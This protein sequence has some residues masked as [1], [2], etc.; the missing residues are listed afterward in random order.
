VSS[1]RASNEAPEPRVVDPERLRRKLGVMSGKLR[2]NV[3]SG[4]KPL[5]GY[6]NV[7]FRDAPHVDVVADASRLPF[8]EGTV[9]EIASFHLVEHFRRHQLASVVLPYWHRLL[10]PGGILRT[11]CP[12]W[13][14][15]LRRLQRGDMTLPDFTLVTFGSQDY[16]G[17]DHFSMYTP[18]TFRTLLASLGFEDIDVVTEARQNGL[19]PEMEI[20]ARKAP[21]E[22]V[23][24]AEFR[25]EPARPGAVPAAAEAPSSTVAAE[26]TPLADA[27][28]VVGELLGGFRDALAIERSSFETWACLPPERY[29]GKDVLDLGC[30]IGASSASFME[31]GA[32]FVWGVDPE[33]TEDR[34]RALRLLPRSRFSSGVLHEID[35]GDQRFDVVYARVVSEHIYDLPR[36]VAIIHSLLRP[37]GCFVG[38]HDNYFGPMG[39]HDQGMFAAVEGSEPMRIERRGPACWTVPEKCEASRDFR[40]WYAKEHDRHALDWA[41]TPESCE[42]CPYYR[43]AQMWGHLLYQ[44]DFPRVYAGE[45]FRTLK[46]GGLNKVTPYQLRQFLVEAGF[47]VTTWKPVMVANAPPAELLERFSRSDLQTGPILFSADRASVASADPRHPNTMSSCACCPGRG[48]D[49]SSVGN[50]KS[51]FSA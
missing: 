31:R 19:C 4:E 21:A 7:D 15:M 35:F 9:D 28:A 47:V 44:D 39:A 27:A 11:V 5:E 34:L 36:A 46:D 18:E 43:R 17:D 23:L 20:V 22:D 30:G 12:N 45:F 26:S 40:G 6:V 48:S 38:L 16:C 33:L 51:V 29:I 2:L 24:E 1:G 49:G 41:L 32:G 10:R 13:D 25:P 50:E 37:G 3:G 42:R 14:E 8:D